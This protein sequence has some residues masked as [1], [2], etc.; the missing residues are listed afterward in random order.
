MSPTYTIGSGSI[1]A[2]EMVALTTVK[3]TSPLSAPT[4]PRSSF[5]SISSEP[6]GWT[7]PSSSSSDR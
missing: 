7:R 2:P 4:S 1:A 6:S 5:S 3:N